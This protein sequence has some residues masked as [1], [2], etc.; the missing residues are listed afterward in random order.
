MYTGLAISIRSLKGVQTSLILFWN[1]VGGIFLTSIYLLV[2]LIAFG[3]P[4]RFSNYT[5]RQLGIAFGSCAFDSISIA[6][7]TIAYKSDK[8]GFV[9]LFTYMNIVYGYLADVFFFDESLNT[10]ELLAAI[11]IIVVALSI[12]VYKLRKK[13]KENQVN[14]VKPQPQKPEHQHTRDANSME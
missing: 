2:E 9:S 11:T 8:S 3:D 5:A 14:E 12:A 7:I 1:S 10:I 13:Q 4:E 6:A